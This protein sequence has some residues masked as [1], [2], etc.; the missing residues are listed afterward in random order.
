MPATLRQA[1]VPLDHSFAEML[2]F[3]LASES[4]FR[5]AEVELRPFAAA[6]GSDPL[7]RAFETEIGH[8]LRGF[9]PEELSCLRDRVWFGS[10]DGT[11]IPL[12]SYLDRHANGLLRAYGRI[13]Q[14][15]PANDQEPDRPYLPA[16]YEGEEAV[17][18]ARRRWRWVS[19]A[20]PPDLLLAGLN[21][22]PQPVRVDTLSPTICD[23]LRDRGFAET[24]LHVG[25]ALDFSQLWT[26]V[27]LTL[28]K[29][30]PKHF[31]SPGA[32]FSDGSLFAPW[33][34]RVAF[35]RCV[36]AAYVQSGFARHADFATYLIEEVFPAHV[37]QYGLGLA[38]SQ[39]RAIAELRYGRFDPDSPEW[40]ELH[41]LYEKLYRDLAGSAADLDDLGLIDPV[42]GFF[43]WKPG[44]PELPESHWMRAVLGHLRQ[45]Q[46]RHQPDYTLA[47]VFWQAVRVRCLFYRHVVQRPLTA[48]IHWFIRFYGRLSPG[49]AWFKGKPA[50]MV[51]AAFRLQGY[52]AGLRS[53]EVR[54]S[55]EK[56]QD[57]TEQLI[58][59]LKDGALA[60]SG[61]EY[62][63][64]LHFTKERGDDTA[65]G[66][67]AAHGRGSHADPG[68]EDDRSRE[69]RNPTRYRFAEY[70]T[71]AWKQANSW[72]QA[73]RANP[74]VLR[75]VRGVD[76]CADERAVPNWV[77]LPLFEMV[78]QAAGEVSGLP[79]GGPPPLRK[80]VHVGEDFVH[81]LTGLRLVAEAV[82]FFQLRAGDR[83]GHALALGVDFADWTTRSGRVWLRRED[84]LFDLVWEWSWCSRRRS[85]A[86]NRLPYLEREI[87]RLGGF[88]FNRPVSPEEVDQLSTDLHTPWALRRMGFP[89]GVGVSAQR[90]HWGDREWLLHQYLRDP[91]TFVRGQE[92]EWF[93]AV[94]EGPVL[95]Y[96][97]SEI[98]REVGQRGVIVEVNPSSNLLIGDFGDLRRHPFWRLASPPGVAPDA[99]PVTVCLGSDDPITFASDIRNEYQLV[100]DAVVSAGVSVD[101][102]LRWVD[103]LRET[104]LAVRFTL[105][106]EA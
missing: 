8:S 1:A 102:A 81:P 104:G 33:L 10:L 82:R 57:E 24:H 94:D 59:G 95:S 96:L 74:D 41:M 34:L 7:W 60:Q 39:L 28:A 65:L 37:K 42:S 4:A 2:A 52:G 99:P 100:F 48:G 93:T 19:F 20:L 64:V 45:R 5:A 47:R 17:A 61:C 85:A 55:P 63:I 101:E 25:A 49:K 79:P 86:P 3:P 53:L 6:D 103:H 58:D 13:A 91:D 105:P 27:Q 77:F 54:T 26:S 50:R 46:A 76:V 92:T 67:P 87:R 70:Y 68:S 73:M 51:Q 75:A 31:A 44:D 90:D 97:Q 98:R 89:D 23:L 83:L 78:Q 18:A 9:T 22:R 35:A 36:T 56:T 15:W 72:A 62:G 38:S 88:V 66:S 84:R 80:T 32:A 69:D 11:R 29:C 43:G 21:S 12:E 40:A 14:P 106:A 30:E 16:D 71:G